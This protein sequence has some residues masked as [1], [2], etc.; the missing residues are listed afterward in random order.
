M[1]QAGGTSRPKMLVMLGI[2]SQKCYGSYPW[3]AVP[4]LAPDREGD[5]EMYEGADDQLPSLASSKTLR[6]LLSSHHP[7]SH[8][9]YVL[10]IPI[11]WQGPIRPVYINLAS[12]LSFKD[13]T[14]TAPQC[15]L[16]R[17][18]LLSSFTSLSARFGSLLRLDLNSFYPSNECC[19]GFVN[20]YKATLSSRLL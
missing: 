15:F 6:H 1:S 13:E 5:L 8:S 10:C 11:C 7:M 17:S 3:K 16:R 20:P 12:A 19:K 14:R 18:P 4:D 2:S 9:T